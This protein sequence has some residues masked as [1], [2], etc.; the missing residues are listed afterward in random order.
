M[1]WY[2]RFF[3]RGTT[4]KHLDAELN[5]HIEQRTADL[6]ATGMATEEARR[7]ARLEFGGLDQVREECRDVGAAQVLETL[8]QDVRYGLRQFRR[9]PGFTVVAVLTLALGI[10]AN[11]AM[12]SVVDGVVLKPLPYPHLER[13]IDV[14][15]SAPKIH[16]PHLG[17]SA[18]MYFIYRQHTRDFE[19]IGMYSGDSVT[20]TGQ[21][22][23]AH[24]RALDV[25][26]G[27]LPLL[28]AQ[29]VLGRLFTPSDDMPGSPD[30][31]MLSYD[32]WQAAFGGAGRALGKRINVDNTPREIIG[33]LPRRF[34]LLDEPNP[35]LILP[36]KLD[37]GATTLGGF[38]FGGI[39]RLRPGMTLEAARADVARM[40]PMVARSFPPPARF[41]VKMYESAQIAPDLRP[42]RD[43]VVGNVES[44][45]WLLMGGIFLVLLIA[46][47]NVANLLLVRMEGCRQEL[48]VRA[49][50]GASR[51]RI[52]RQ[53]LVE[54]AALSL[55]GGSLGLAFAY[56]ALRI[57]LALAPGNLP[58]LNEIGIDGTLLLF[59]FG[60]SLVASLL[61]GSIA[62][63]GYAGLNPG[64]G[65]R[66]SGRSLTSTR[67]R[68]L[69]RG[70][71]TIGQV[72][73]AL[74]LLISSGLMIRTY[75]AVLHVQPGFS[76]APDEVQTFN[77]FI[78]ST[79]IPK[80]EQVAHMQEQ[81][82]RRI[83]A[84][85]GVSSA[86]ISTSV[87]MDGN[88]GYEPLFVEDHPELQGKLPTLCWYNFVSPGY[89]QSI[90]ARLIAGRDF[91]WRDIYA[92][93]PAVLISE[94]LARDYWQDPATALG[95]QIRMGATDQWHEI[96]GLVGDIHDEGMNEPAPR[97]VHWPL[98]TTSF[99]GVPV[100]AVRS[101]RFAIRSSRAG[102]ASLVKEIERATW[103]V[104]PALPLTDVQTLAYYS[105]KSMARTAFTFFLLALAGGMALLLG[106]VGLYGVVSYMT[107][108]RTQ[109]I[110]IRMALGA[111]RGD[112]LRLVVSQGVFLALM[113]V[114]IGIPGALALTRFMSGLLYGVKPTDPL[115]FI[116]V[117]LILTVVA[118]L[119][120]YMPACRATKVDPMVALR[121]E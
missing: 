28:G 81:I 75:R 27:L 17:M 114:G 22:E 117:S 33:V 13:L 90:G 100:L 80:P 38:D 55:P 68:H 7:Q 108:Q 30:T 105:S 9:S 72:G 106:S 73:L 19:D 112:V 48:A 54:S 61:F 23:P 53:L 102:S 62:I 4:E 37:P 77:L 18:S 58:R 21:A 34:R 74:V 104:D 16:T 51:A 66:E 88:L 91:T 70:V 26:D 42:L 65:M 78:S 6:V 56:G 63:L 69:T 10:G 49:A 36:I 52:A 20:V 95:K 110:G 97:E 50:L 25:T 11:T 118:L 14:S 3:R 71:L 94:N 101:F 60:V 46:C 89:F 92:K 2:Q 67:E 1:R 99:Q 15:H 35:A 116:V 32:Y 45:L 44:V 41:S 85:P 87:P 109:E 5:F 76:A 43:R 40:L 24:V 57:L 8:A 59:A 31:V 113:G 115:T 119:A 86:A 39:A 93:L 96:V 103:S 47:A 98:V 107:S 120:S 111:G 29:A 121:H 82:L 79:E 64:S 12:F 83:E 84:I